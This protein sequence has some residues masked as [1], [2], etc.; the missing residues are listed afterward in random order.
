MFLFRSSYAS[1][2]WLVV[3]LWLG[4]EWFDAGWEKLTGKG[5]G[6]WLTHDVGLEGFLA[7]GNAA[8]VHRAETGG[9]P[10]VAYLWAV[11]LMNDITPHAQFFST[12]DTFSELA[13]GLGLLLGCLTGNSGQ[14]SHPPSPRH[15]GERGSRRRLYCTGAST[16]TTG[17]VRPVAGQSAC[18]LKRLSA[19]ATRQT[20]LQ[21][22]VAVVRQHLWVSGR[23]QGVW[24]R[25]ACAEQARALGVSGWARNLPDGR[26][27][28]V[29]EGPPEAVGQLVEW[30]RLGPPAA[31]VTG[32]QSEPEPPEGVHGF[33]TR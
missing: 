20:F 29:V 31:R 33:T 11:H 32:V 5:L 10:D 9:H 16:A 8:W 23:V 4:W 7:A 30:C 3:R 26:V 13:V 15:P 18:L 14:C 27:E 1:P 25:G 28:V 2:I 19:T 21:A 12:V 24:Y 17:N 6:N 22:A